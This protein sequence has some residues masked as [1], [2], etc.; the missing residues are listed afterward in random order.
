MNREGF[1]THPVAN[2]EG[3]GHAAGDQGSGPRHLHPWE[4]SPWKATD[5]TESMKGS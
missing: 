5:F 1:H 2:G 3:I 4:P